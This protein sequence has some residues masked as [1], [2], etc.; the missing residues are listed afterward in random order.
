[1]KKLSVQKR[2]HF[3][4][5][6]D[7]IYAL[8][9]HRKDTLFYTGGAEGYVVQWDYLQGGDGHLMATLPKPV[10]S[11]AHDAE[12]HQLLAGSSQGNLH[13]ISLEE[14]KESRNIEAHQNGLFD[15]CLPATHPLV[16]TAGGDGYIRV[17]DKHS[18][19]L[20]HQV[21]ASKKSARVI[22][23]NHD[24]S[25]LA[26][27]FSDQH[28]RLY[29]LADF[30]LQE[31]WEAQQNSVFAL[32]Y[33]PDRKHLLSGGRDAMLNVWTP[34][35]SLLAEKSI[36]AHLLHINSIAFSPS[37]QLFATASMDKTV[38]IW[39]A[40]SFEL[41]KVVDHP[42]NQGHLSSVNKI[43][44]LTDDYLLSCGDD[45]CAMSWDLSWN[46]V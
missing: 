24:E 37:G 45:R 8:A 5:H 29:N 41:L 43:H 13:L 31:D 36:P 44:W 4:G 12:T 3:S 32:A 19:K 15:I 11:L 10:Y 23:L 1:M 6:K 22:A 46:Q 27:G 42:R 34:A 35:S 30:T 21:E 7:C 18:L 40:S 14:K 17:W 2:F 16:I 9:V 28:V 33:S 39:D 25:Q 26:V 38:K 20:F